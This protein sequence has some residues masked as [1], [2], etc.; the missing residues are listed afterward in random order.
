MDF[1]YLH[2][3][4]SGEAGDPAAPSFPVIPMGVVGLC[5]ALRAEGH[6]V[7]GLNLAVERL[8]EPGLM[9]RDILDRE[10]APELVLVDL[11]WHVHL[12]GALELVAW[13]RETW[14]GA[15]VLLG[16][17]TASA[18]A[19]G[20]LSSS[21]EL[22]GVIRGDAEAPLLGLART[23]SWPRAALPNLVTREHPSPPRWIASA[24]D[25]DPLDMVDLGFLVRPEAYRRLLYSHPRRPGRAPA[26]GWRGHW[27]SNG[28]GCAFDC[29]ACGGSRSAHASLSGRAAITWR[30]PAVLVEELARLRALGVEQA[31]L[32]LDPELA[33]AEHRDACLAGAAG[34]GLYIESFQLPSRGLLDGLATL[35]DLDHSELAISALSGS[36]A[37]R[38]RHGKG[39]GDRAL[40]EAVDALLERGL[41]A[42]VFFSLGL[43]G[44]DE[45]AFGASLA[46]AARILERDRAGL[47]RLAAQPQALDP[48]AP[49]ARDPAA[50][51][52]E[53]TDAGDLAARLE[54]ARGLAEGSLHPLDARA[55]GYR[56]PGCD[57]R[58]RAARWNEL[59]AQAPE[60]VQAVPGA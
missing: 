29:G 34:L 57:L 8:H 45:A 42:S 12:L 6:R 23:G 52:F 4:A 25:L 17:L 7:R 26:P 27:L 43:P 18:Y 54:R 5:N 24:E 31:A 58:E 14:P 2:P 49:M 41:S 35:A 19:A 33:G 55:L 32:G 51:G 37:L 44:E 21:P 15:K 28:R 60:A 36:E 46:L 59:A 3:L 16:G 11:H 40:L 13:A 53:P 30:S 47:L 56:V 38:R 1:L 48:G 10:P 39:L 22:D 20:L 9:S 50:W